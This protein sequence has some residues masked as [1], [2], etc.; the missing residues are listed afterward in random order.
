MYPDEHK[1]IVTS[2]MEG[3]FI[4]VDDLFFKTIKKNEE[5]YIFALLAFVLLVL[6][7]LLRNTILRRIP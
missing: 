7:V 4:T 3:K 6:E 5:F 2:L 1:E